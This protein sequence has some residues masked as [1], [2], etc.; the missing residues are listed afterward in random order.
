MIVEYGDSVPRVFVLRVSHN[1]IINY[2]Y[3][4]VDDTN[5]LSVIVDPAW[6]I[7]K[8]EKTLVFTRTSLKGILLT[9]SH[10]DHIDLAIPLSLK[11]N[12][13]IWMSNVEIATSNFKAERLVG[14]DIIPWFV[15]HIQI[16]P[17]F[18]PG[19]S[20]GS[21]CYLIGNSLFTGDT[22]FAEGCGLCFN[23]IAASAMYSSIELLKKRIKPETRVFPG[24]SYG[25][26]PG[27]KFSL[28][29]KENIY[30]QFNNEDDFVAYRMR[31]G[32]K[33]KR[34]FDFQ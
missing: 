3:L 8:I 21:T 17:I 10:P 24:H 1:F 12:C 22:L 18:T 31:I 26:I 7:E 11:Y 23:K 27:Q 34:F 29:L 16:Q 2:N 19:H 14:V 4:I 30:L 9:H 13:P 32:Q 6:D 15:G 20:L 25:K 28:L 33:T 5:N